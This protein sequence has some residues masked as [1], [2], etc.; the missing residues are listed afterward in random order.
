VVTLL[1]ALTNEWHGLIWSEITPIQTQTGALVRYTHG[2]WFWIF[3]IY[4]YIALVAGT[5][6]LI[7][8][9]ARF[10]PEYRQQTIYLVVGA[11]S[12]IANIA[13]LSGLTASIVI[14]LTRLLLRPASSTPIRCSD[15]TCSVWCRSPMTALSK[16]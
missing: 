6:I 8:G 1:L 9:A 16:V 15:F 14:D 5:I 13:Y 12:L 11:R 10:S 7:I 4:G 2:V 3:T